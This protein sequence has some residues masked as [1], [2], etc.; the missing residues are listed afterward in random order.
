MLN[1]FIVFA[2]PYDWWAMVMGDGLAGLTRA[3]YK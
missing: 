1:A 2:I 3:I